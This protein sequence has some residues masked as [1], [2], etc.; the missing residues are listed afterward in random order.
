MSLKFKLTAIE[1]FTNPTSRVIIILG[2]LLIA[3]LVGG[4]PSDSGW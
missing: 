2:T 3:A 4:A 1:L